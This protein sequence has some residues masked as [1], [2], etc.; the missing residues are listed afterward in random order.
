MEDFWV[1]F[2]EK[3]GIEIFL[4]TNILLFALATTVFIFLIMSSR[5]K[6][7]RIEIY[8][9]K[10]TKYIE[11]CLFSVAFDGKNFEDIRQQPE[12]EKNWQRKHFKNRFLEELIKLHRLFE[13]ENEKNLKKFYVSSGLM[14]L[15]FKKIRSN[16][17]AEK[18]A[19]IHELSE[20]GI[21]KAIPV[22]QEHTTSKNET[23]RMVSLT[24][25]LNLKGFQGLHIFENYEEYLNDWMQL[26]LLETIR[27]NKI[28]EAPDFGHLLESRN[29][30]IVIFGLRLITTFH[31]DDHFSDIKQLQQSAS[32]KIRKQATIT[33]A[34][35]SETSSN[36]F[37]EE[38]RNPLQI[39][40]LKFMSQEKESYSK[41]ALKIVIFGALFVTA[42]VIGYLVFLNHF[43]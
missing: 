40:E 11:K 30:S 19:G 12:F 24:E 26:N 6:K 13:G 28:S 42:L 38:V 36:D 21:K 14:Q 23:L 16:N 10:N 37:H 2:L 31:Q 8:N 33:L 29:E 32:A 22:I 7:I 15:S 4:L 20:M 34:E 39:P 35:L 5:R 43:F 41:S 25:F 27:K 3:P 17:W 1:N 18:C 9:R